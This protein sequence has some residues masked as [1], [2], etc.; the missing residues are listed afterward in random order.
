MTNVSK[1]RRSAGRK[2]GLWSAGI[3]ALALATC[4]GCNDEIRHDVRQGAY[5]VFSAGLS[6]V[7]SELSS[8]ITSGISD[9]A[10]KSSAAN[11]QP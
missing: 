4:A 6:S 2:L 9:L 5:D 11:R 8:G 1:M 3:A 10:S 7:Y